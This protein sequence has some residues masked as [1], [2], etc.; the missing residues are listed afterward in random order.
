MQVEYDDNN[1]SIISLSLQTYFNR[2]QLGVVAI[3]AIFRKK[4]ND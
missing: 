4:S 1:V 2:F 3:I